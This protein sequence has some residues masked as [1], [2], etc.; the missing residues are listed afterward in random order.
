[1]TATGSTLTAATLT[2]STALRPGHLNPALRTDHYE[3]TMVDAALASGVAHH[4]AVFELFTR[5][6]GTGRRFGVVAGTGRLLDLL[7]E[8]RFDADELDWL[9]ATGVIG[10]DAAEFLAGWRFTGDIDGYGEGEL[11]FADSP[12]LTVDG[13]FAS[14]VVIETLALSVFNHDAAVASA[15]ARFRLAAPTKRLLEGGSRRTHDMAAVAAAR[16]AVIAGFDATSNLGAGYAYG[17]PTAG[18]AAHAFTMA[19]RDEPTAFVA[20]ASRLGKQ[21]TFLVDTF[22][23]ADGVRHAL[24]ATDGRLGGVRI[25]SG[26][27]AANARLAR[28]LLDGAG[29]TQATVCVSGDLDEY[30]IAELEASGAPIDAYLAGTALVTGSGHPTAGFV[31]KLV[32]V[33]DQP[34]PDARMRPVAK[35]S[36]AKVSVGGRKTAWRRRD[37]HGLAGAEIADATTAAVPP[38]ARALQVPLMRSGRRVNHDTVNDAR[39]RLQTALAE[40]P[41][42]ARDLPAGAPALAVQVL[43]G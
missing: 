23:V 19:H 12:I 27:L 21:S 25:D 39:R 16:A 4:R 5:R 6:L 10:A 9:C 41:A 30:A 31:Y 28:R 1:M 33:A 37:T 38:G 15:A 14:A 11:F 34:G 24:A 36:P 43:G 40:L 7:E 32:A 22:D 26:D 18:T 13:D 8:F 20:Q 3:L 17:L 29:A 42:Q 35:R 2:D